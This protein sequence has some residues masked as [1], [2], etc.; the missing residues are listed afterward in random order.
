M[1]SEGERQ[2]AMGVL[3]ALKATHVGQC[4]MRAQAEE[5]LAKIKAAS[6]CHYHELINLPCPRCGENP[7]QHVHAYV[8]NPFTTV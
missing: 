1:T 7:Q 5:V 2:Y 6:H 8:S 3:A 4:Q